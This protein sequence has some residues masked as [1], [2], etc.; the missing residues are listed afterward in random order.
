[1]LV[2]NNGNCGLLVIV[3]GRNRTAARVVAHLGYR[4]GP[5]NTQGI[6]PKTTKEERDFG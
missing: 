1:M 6:S 4:P 3:T 5:N 2:C